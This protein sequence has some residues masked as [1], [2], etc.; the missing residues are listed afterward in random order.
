[1]ELKPMFA[2]IREISTEPEFKQEWDDKEAKEVSKAIKNL[3]E[4]KTLTDHR[5]Q[6][7]T[8]YTMDQ[9]EDFFG[10]PYTSSSSFAMVSNCNTRFCVDK[11][12]QYNIEYFALTKD[13][14]VIMGAWDKDEN[15]KDFV[16]G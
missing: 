6:E 2:N 10:L 7:R 14:K 1:M 5:G 16:I 12:E 15:E 8:L 9:I 3:F 13:N 4:M 11:E